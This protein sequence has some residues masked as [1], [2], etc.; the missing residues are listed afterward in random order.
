MQN[1]QISLNVEFLT[2][3]RIIQCSV[4]AKIQN[5]ALDSALL[6][7]SKGV[8]I[9]LCMPLLLHL[10]WRGKYSSNLS[11]VYCLRSNKIYN[12]A[13]KNNLLKVLRTFRMDTRTLSSLS[14]GVCFLISKKQT[15]YQKISKFSLNS[16]KFVNLPNQSVLNK[17]F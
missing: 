12:R 2:E 17:I 9:Q 7:S 10:L 1:P 3:C 11:Q 8:S 6:L 15:L 4:C 14:V 13:L 16:N 5:L